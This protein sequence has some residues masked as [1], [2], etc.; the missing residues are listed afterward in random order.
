GTRGR[1]L[2]PS[3]AGASV[4]VEVGQD[5]TAVAFALEGKRLAAACGDF[6]IRLYPAAATATDKVKELKGH[7]S[8]VTVLRTVGNGKQ[9]LS[10]S[11]DGSLRLWNAESG[12]ED[13]KMDHGAPVTDLGVQADGKRGV[14]AAGTALK[15]WKTNGELQSTLKGDRRAADAQTTAELTAA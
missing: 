4:A 15:I 3:A 10:G 12:K 11:E 1:R 5:I 14:S 8:K 7:G 6:L 2:G 13:R 9:L